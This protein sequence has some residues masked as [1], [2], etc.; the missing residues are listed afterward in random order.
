[1]KCKQTKSPV[2]TSLTFKC[3]LIS[4]DKHTTHVSP[5]LYLFNKKKD[6]IVFYVSYKKWRPLYKKNIW[7]KLS[8]STF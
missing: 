7:Y 6:V 8:Y 1:M 3:I 5:F 4:T 2:Q